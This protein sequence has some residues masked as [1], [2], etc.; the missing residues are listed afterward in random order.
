[1]G[2]LYNLKAERIRAGLSTSDMATLIGKTVDTYRNKENG[3]TQF[4]LTEIAAIAKKL[5]MSIDYLFED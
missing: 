1:M 5:N 3:K 2:K 4:R